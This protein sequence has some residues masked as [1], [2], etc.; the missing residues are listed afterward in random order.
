MT[1]DGIERNMG[2]Q[3]I[4]RLLDEAGLRPHD[5]VKASAV[6]MTHKMVSRACKGRRLTENTQTIVLNALQAA[7][8]RTFELKDLFN[9][10]DESKE[11]Q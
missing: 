11:R 9:Y 5:L 2:E 10:A 4:A 7:T 6:Q 8:G 1:D 3:P